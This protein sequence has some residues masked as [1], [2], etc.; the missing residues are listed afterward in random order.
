MRKLYNRVFSLDERL[1]DEFR[2][3]PVQIVEKNTWLHFDRIKGAYEV[4]F[5]KKTY[6]VEPTNKTVS[7]NG[8]PLASDQ[9][10]QL[11]LVLVTYL[12]QA[13]EEPLSGAMVNEKQLKGG[14]LFFQGPHTLNRKPIIDRYGED[15]AGFRELGE[16]FGGTPLE[17]GDVSFRIKTL[18]KVPMEF[19]L[20]CK[21]DEFPADLVVLFDSSIESH[22]KLDVVWALVN[23]TVEQLMA[24]S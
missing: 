7:R 13:T 23:V 1:W 20:Y 17:Y 9:L 22:F 5:L 11:Q 19:I 21:D 15:P 8:E 3:K 10:F 4:P 6:H 16:G 24:L 12:A 18:P 14:T 2:E